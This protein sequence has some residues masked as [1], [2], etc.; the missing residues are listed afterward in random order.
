MEDSTRPLGGSNLEG[1]VVCVKSPQPALQ[2]EKDFGPSGRSDH[3]LVIAQTA[4]VTMVF[5]TLQMAFG[6]A[7]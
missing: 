4:S 6:V 1:L 2:M 7:F 3:S 5:G